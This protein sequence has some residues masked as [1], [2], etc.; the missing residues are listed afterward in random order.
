MSSVRIKMPPSGFTPID[1]MFIDKYLASARGDFI[2]VYIYCLRIGFENQETAID[3][4][5]EAL[6]LLETDVIKAFEYWEEAGIMR[7]NPEGLIEIYPSSSFNQSPTLFFNRQIK[8]MIDDIEKIV[9]RPLSSKEVSVFVNTLEDFNFTPEM[10]TLLVEYCS[11]K[12]KTDIRYIEKVALGWYDSGVR[13]YE[14]AQNHI[15]KHEDKWVKYRTILNFLGFKDSEISKPQEEIMEKWLYKF[16]FPVDVIFEAARI[17][18]MRINEV[19]FNYM[20][21]ILA[22][23]HKTGIKTLEDVKKSV[24]KPR[25]SKSPKKNTSNTFASYGG[26]RQYDISELKKQLL[27]R[28]DEDEQ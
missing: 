10:V 8:E 2:K 17:C 18:T 11:A 22:D 19:N 9:G 28:S 21:A 13:T 16:G 23:W 12:N 20:D 25:E 14:D 5:G 27:G 6:N 26:Q 4:I 1:N 15:T 24:K 7:L 3:K